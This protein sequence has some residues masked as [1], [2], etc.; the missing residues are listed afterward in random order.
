MYNVKLNRLDKLQEYIFEKNSVSL[1]ELC[2]VFGI[3]LVTLRRDLTLLENQGI[4]K[5]TYGG[6]VCQSLR[7][8]VTPYEERNIINIE[9]KRDIA[10]I[11]ASLIEPGDIIFIDSGST[12]MFLVEYISKIENITVLTNNMSI[13][14]QAIL[15]DNI[16]LITL[17]GIFNKTSKS[18]I[19]EHSAQILMEYNITKSFLGSTGISITN[20]ITNSISA[21]KEIKKLAAENSQTSI[22]LV[23]YNKIDVVSLFTYSKLEDIDILITDRPL[24]KNYE[25]YLRENNVKVIIAA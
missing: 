19:G 12:N 25:I 2:S 10:R 23:D 18:F 7:H 14:A 15:M 9:G 21:E 16:Q 22:V 4:I 20:G 6:V 24:A 8:I 5:K 3:S 1:K 11:A 17:S 13:I